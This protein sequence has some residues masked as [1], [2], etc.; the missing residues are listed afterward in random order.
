MIKPPALLTGAGVI[1]ALAAVAR[2]N[3]SAAPKAIVVDLMCVLPFPD[4]SLKSIPT[5]PQLEGIS[6]GN[7]S[8]RC[9]QGNHSTD[10]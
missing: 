4:G 5:T 8:I 2:P 9:V 1:A 7:A 10:R 6:G 3:S